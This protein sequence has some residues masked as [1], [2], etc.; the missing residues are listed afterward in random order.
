MSGYAG[1]SWGTRRWKAL[2]EE[3]REP[4]HREP[5]CAQRRCGAAPPAWDFCSGKATPFALGLGVRSLLGSQGAQPWPSHPFHLMLASRFRNS[6]PNRFGGFSQLNV[7]LSRDRP[8][9]LPGIYQVQEKPSSKQKPA[10][11]CS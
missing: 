6:P 10:R 3:H 9:S 2:T 11:R 5:A 8:I 1:T 4:E 7:C